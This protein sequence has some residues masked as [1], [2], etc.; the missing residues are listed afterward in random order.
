MIRRKHFEDMFF[1]VNMFYCYRRNFRAIEIS[2]I[3]F[4]RKKKNLSSSEI[5]TEPFFSFY[6]IFLSAWYDSY[7]FIHEANFRFFTCWCFFIRS[8]LF[9]LSLELY[10]IASYTKNARPSKQ[11]FWLSE[12]TIRKFRIGSTSVCIKPVL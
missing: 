3:C 9:P 1:F 12:R 8:S 6:P 4:K 5:F 11:Q 2:L 7:S 10:R